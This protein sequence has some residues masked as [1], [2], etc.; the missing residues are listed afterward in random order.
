MDTIVARTA[1]SQL[2]PLTEAPLGRPL[3]VGKVDTNSVDAARLQ[4]MG[5]CQGR[6]LEVVKGGNPLV[7]RIVGSRVG[8]AARLA[9]HVLIDASPVEPT[10]RPHASGEAVDV[11]AV[12][13]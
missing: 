5:V 10:L 1:S 2:L 7:V 11:L 13:A 8:I 9:I 4:A 12:T 6:V 3:R